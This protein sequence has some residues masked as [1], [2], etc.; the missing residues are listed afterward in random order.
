[1][2]PIA[3]WAAGVLAPAAALIFAAWFVLFAL[4]RGGFEAVERHRDRRVGELLLRTNPRRPPVS[5]IAAWRAAELT[6]ASR[7]HRLKGSVCQLRRET[8]ACVLSRHPAALAAALDESLVLIARLE[9][10]LESSPE[11]VEPL[12]MLEAR[13]LTL[14]ALDDLS[15]LYYPERADDLRSKLAEALVALEPT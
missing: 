6:S 9:D 8:E 13:V 3:L 5:A 10:R 2:L 12:G 7:R 14:E 15:P 4:I 1:V 11:P